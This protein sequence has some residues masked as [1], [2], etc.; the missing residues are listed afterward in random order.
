MFDVEPIAKEPI[1]LHGRSH[2]PLPATSSL[3]PWALETEQRKRKNQQT[4]GV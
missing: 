4:R 2:K 1:R 3:F